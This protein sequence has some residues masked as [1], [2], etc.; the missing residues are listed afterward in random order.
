[1]IYVRESRYE[2]YDPRARYMEAERDCYDPDIVGD[3]TRTDYVGG[4]VYGDF[5]VSNSGGKP[6]RT[7]PLQDSSA[8]HS[9]IGRIF[10]ESAPIGAV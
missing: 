7:T 3:T 1:M 9:I 5:L 8:F 4:T 6:A 10:R 2:Y